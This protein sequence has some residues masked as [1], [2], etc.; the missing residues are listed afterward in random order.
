MA[1]RSL[2][3]S[4]SLVALPAAAQNNF[5]IT[6]HG[7]PAGKASYSIEKTKDGFHVKS[8]MN[9]RLSASSQPQDGD[10]PT[11][12]RGRGSAAPGIAGD[13][14][15]VSEY[16]LDSSSIYAGGFTT[17][18]VTLVNTS[19]TVNKSRDQLF[20]S[21]NQVGNTSLSIPMAIKPD[22]VLLPDYDPSALQCFLL[23]TIA[24]PA[25]KDLYT[26]VTPGKRP[27]EEAVPALW[28]ADQPDA[29]GTLGDRPLT[30]HHFILRL[31]KAEYDLFA[32]ET[33]TLMLATSTSLSAIYTRDGFVLTSVK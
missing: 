6:V 13:F 19:Y 14:Q 15:F 17:N 11:A 23:Q 10:A 30:L 5:I 9:Y 16:K 1:V 2:A 29:H 25:A 20:T 27:G 18:M 7:K 31:Y 22:F 8:K 24:H 33:N 28:L 4:I 32:D 26:V 12:A 21:R 3:L